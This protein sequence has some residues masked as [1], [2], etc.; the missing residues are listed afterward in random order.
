MHCKN[1][2]SLLE[3]DKLEENIVEEA[4]NGDLQ[5]N[6]KIGLVNLGNTC[7]LSSV[8]QT[9][10]HYEPIFRYFLENNFQDLLKFQDKE[11]FLVL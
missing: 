5:T 4:K 11:P 10:L 2:I 8:F 7:Y 3:M 1:I 9:F 6:S